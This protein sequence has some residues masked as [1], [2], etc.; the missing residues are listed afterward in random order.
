LEYKYDD[1]KIHRTY[2]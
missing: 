1:M 2:L